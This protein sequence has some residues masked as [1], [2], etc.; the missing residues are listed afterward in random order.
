MV[1]PEDRLL[2]HDYDGV[3]EYDNPLPRW[4][5]IIFYGTIAWAGVYV[6]Y[7]LAGPGPSPEESY[8]AEM[9]EAEALYKK[10]EPKKLSGSDLAALAKDPEALALGKTVYTKNCVPCHAPDG[11][12]LVGPNFTDYY[13]I[14]GE[15]L[16]SIVHT[17]QEGVP[18]KGMIPWKTVL[19]P[20]EVHAVAVYVKAF[21][22]TTPKNPKA[23]EGK[24]FGKALEG[25]AGDPPPAEAPG[26]K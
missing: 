6:P 22:G 9:K 4:W 25:A 17:I 11:G 21:E 20:E 19:K 13:A 15:D 14:H 5:L 8:A 10:P 26:K 24:P 23:P 18:A 16:A 2:D 7:Y 1:E 3:R 12:G